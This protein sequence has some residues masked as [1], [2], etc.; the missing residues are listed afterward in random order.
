M[1]LRHN[2]YVFSNGARGPQELC[3]A[4]HGI[5]NYNKYDT[6]SVS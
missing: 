2:R 4:F 6:H 5:R 3:G 1:Q